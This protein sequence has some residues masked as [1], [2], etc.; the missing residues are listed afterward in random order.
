[1]E[2]N[3]IVLGGGS[4][5]TALANLLAKKGYS[6]T[7]WLRDSDLVKSIN[8]NKENKK[9]LPGVPLSENL[10]ATDSL[11]IFGKEAGVV[12]SAIPTQGV[13][14][15]LKKIK[16]RIPGDSIIVNVS[17]GIET[18]SLL[19]I[20]EIVKAELGDVRYCVLS[21]PSHAEEVGKDMPTTV[22]VS[23]EEREAAEYV[24][25]MFMTDR[26]RVYTNPDVIGVELGGSLK[27]IIALGAGISDG[28]GFGDNSKAALMSRGFVE[29]TR[30]GAALGASASTF[31]GLSGIGDLIVTCTSVHSRNTRAGNLIGQGYSADE[32]CEKVGMVVEGMKTTKAAYDLAQR[33][34][35]DMPITFEL[36]RVLFEGADV[37]EAMNNLMTRTKKHELEEM[38]DKNKILWNR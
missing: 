28:I 1:M 6:V 20:S 31:T 19:R 26:F 38:I 8:E 4:W 9:Y 24:Q 10:K 18:E 23:S 5:G 21:G 29:M 12:V 27:N 33:L 37:G 13:R 17:K 25:D 3:I 2:Q 16:G 15:V 34:E 14:D 22:V 32:A 11:D 7:M 30:L 36:Y 35:V